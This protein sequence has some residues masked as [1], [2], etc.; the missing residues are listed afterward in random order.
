MPGSSLQSLNS[1]V[2]AHRSQIAREVIKLPELFNE[3]E[4]A[5]FLTLAPQTLRGW[6][7]EGR[8]PSFIRLGTGKRTSIRY[9]RCDLQSFIEAG[10][11]P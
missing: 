4:A 2:K 8:G 6:R 1:R 11:V 10:R 9:D 3:R 5:T 7:S